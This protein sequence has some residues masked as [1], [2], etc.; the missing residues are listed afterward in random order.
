MNIYLSPIEHNELNL[1]ISKLPSNIN[2]SV[3]KINPLEKTHTDI[4]S[5]CNTEDIEISKFYKKYQSK[6]K[7]KFEETK[8]HK[9]LN[10]IKVFFIVKSKV[11]KGKGN[12]NHSV[13]KINPLEKTHTDIDSTCNT[14]D[15]EISKFYKKYQSKKKKKFEETKSHK[16]LNQIKVFFIV[17]SKVVKGKEVRYAIPIRNFDDLGNSILEKSNSFIASV[18][19]LKADHHLNGLEYIEGNP[20][21]RPFRLDGIIDPESP[22]YEE[23]EF[24]LENLILPKKYVVSQGKLTLDKESEMNNLGKMVV[25]ESQAMK[26]VF[27]FPTEYEYTESMLDNTFLVNSSKYGIDIRQK[28]SINGAKEKN[29]FLSRLE[30]FNLKEDRFKLFNMSNIFELL[31]GNINASVDKNIIPVF[32][33]LEDAQDL[34]ITILDEINQPFQ[35][36]RKIEDY[37]T[38]QYSKSLSYLDDSFSFHNNYFLPGPKSKLER[39][40]YLLIKYGIFKSS[41][42]SKYSDH[43]FYNENK[44]QIKGPFYVEDADTIASNDAYVPTKSAPKFIWREVDYWSFLNYYFPGQQESYSWWESRDMTET[45]KGLLKK[46]QEIKIISMGLGDFLEFWNNP[47][48][49]N[50]EVLFIPS[51]TDLNTKKLSLL[52]RNRKPKDKFYN[53]QQKFRKLKKP[54]TENYMYEIKL[55]A[56]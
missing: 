10:Q 28:N 3:T 43:D 8:S 23:A 20:G 2:H 46:S 36:R 1:P 16:K 12:I 42:F 31:F 9:K 35:V 4:D 5:T 54:N 53:Y 47:T 29:S 17:K 24:P 52:P 56:E 51:S 41:D 38:T 48:I 6:K 15:I 22:F 19:Y 33:S 40:Q 39:A 32:S 13:T 25:E 55:S 44:Y 27:S 18:F 14:E 50:G 30:D 26:S 7:K 21:A 11:V 49:K 37:N 34:L 45:D